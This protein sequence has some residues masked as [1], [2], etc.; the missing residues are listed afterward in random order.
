MTIE[1]QDIEYKDFSKSKVIDKKKVI[2]K[3]FKEITAFAN[4]KGGKI[5]VGK[6]D[7]TGII[8]KQPREII[9]LLDNDSLTSEIN[10]ISDN[11]VVFKCEQDDDLIIVTIQES[12]DAISANIDY[13]GINNGDC[14]IRENHQAIPAKG[15]TLKKLIERKTISVDK[16][17][18]ALRK[19]VHHKFSKG[20]NH[21]SKMNIFDSLVVTNSSK[22][23]FIKTVFDS[24]M[25]NQFL[26]GYKLP[27]SKYTTMKL[28]LDTMALILK[29][30]DN[31]KNSIILN[32]NAFNDLKKNTESIESFFN[33]H[34]DEALSSPQLKSYILE[35]REVVDK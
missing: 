18:K 31:L 1:T 3:L 34:R 13:K 8:N 23:Y 30:P 33:S 21:A 26:G 2:S 22:E 12:D 25:M 15:N 5:I 10:R 35:N 17:L 9:D 32:R 29:N 28:H 4:S 27:L 19:I 20:E 6:E 11:L 24:F 7:K 14:F 16:K